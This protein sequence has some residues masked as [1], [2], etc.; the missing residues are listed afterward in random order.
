MSKVM[1]KAIHQLIVPALVKGQPSRRIEPG[2]LV[3]VDEDTAEFLLQR[4]AATKATKAEIKLAGIEAEESQG[5][6]EDPAPAATVEPAKTEAPEAD[7]GNKKKKNQAT[8]NNE[9]V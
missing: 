4:E 6:V 9:L 8:D 1:L 7:A 2:S 5:V 3:E